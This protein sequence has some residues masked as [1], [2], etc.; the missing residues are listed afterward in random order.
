[1][2]QIE[3]RSNV[4]KPAPT[5]AVRSPSPRA[6]RRHNC[7]GKW[8]NARTGLRHRSRRGARP[9]ARHA[10][11]R[12]G[13][14]PRACKRVRHAQVGGFGPVLPVRVHPILECL[15]G[16]AA[17][18]RVIGA[19]VVFLLPSDTQTDRQPHQCQVLEVYRV[20]RLIERGVHRRSLSHFSPWSAR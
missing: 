18:R 19:E 4:G 11:L 3:A 9:G 16:G 10:S 8:R 12:N 13:A 1:M 5:I 6:A 14:R 20:D 17:R 15:N 2:S 7:G